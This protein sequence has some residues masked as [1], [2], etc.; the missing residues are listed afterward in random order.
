MLTAS[1][2][3]NTGISF[4]FFL[5]LKH[6]LSAPLVPCI[7]ALMGT[8]AKEMSR[9]AEQWGWGRAARKTACVSYPSAFGGKTEHQANVSEHVL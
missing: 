2:V 8:V 4:P 1:S 3:C 5:L 9:V 7:V 6:N